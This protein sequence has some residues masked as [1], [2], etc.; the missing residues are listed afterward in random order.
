MYPAVFAFP[1]YRQ[2]ERLLAGYD[3]APRIFLFLTSL[4]LLKYFADS[5]LSMCCAPAG[6]G[7]YTLQLIEKAPDRSL[8]P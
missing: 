7:V 1:T 2:S 5:A 4:V 8:H 6:R 3:V